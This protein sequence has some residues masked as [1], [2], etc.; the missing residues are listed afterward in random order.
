MTADFDL[1]NLN[2]YLIGM[3]GCG[4]STTGKLLAQKLGYRFFD[5]DDLITQSTGLTV[6]QIF[7]EAG[8]AEFRKVET[9][10]LSQLSAYTR[11]VVATGGGIVLERMN[12]SHMQQGLVIWLEVEPETLLNRLK[13]DTARPLLQ[14]ADPQQTLRILLAQRNHLYAQ[15]DIKVH[16][17]EQD[18]PEAIVSAIVSEIPHV[19]RHKPS[20]MTG[21]QNI[22]NYRYISD[23]L[24]TSGQPTAEEFALIHRAGYRTVLNLA[25]ANA[26]NALPNEQAIV[27]SLGMDYINIAVVWENPTM[28]D[29]SRFCAVMNTCQDQPLFVHCAMNMRVSAFVYLYR[30]LI[31][32]IPSP[33]AYEA[34][35]EIWQPNETWQK[36][37]ETVIAF[38][39][40]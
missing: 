16:V 14:N 39:R 7:A 8:E 25:P 9:Q 12:W 15:A 18:L 4:K 31:L 35:T 22:L 34:M 32:G 24:A 10:V 5:T 3:M 6:S 19:L 40:K 2:V 27:A 20:M 38:Y 11:L 26:S 1:Q 13:E 33:E 28:E 29:F 17:E 36:F 23:K 37:I 30:D 21:L